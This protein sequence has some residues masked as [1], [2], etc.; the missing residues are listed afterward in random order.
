[1]RSELHVID[2]YYG[3]KLYSIYVELT[4]ICYEVYNEQYMILPDDCNAMNDYNKCDVLI[5]DI[6]VLVF[7][8]STGDL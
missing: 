1:M 6:W 3:Q 7:V 8:Y 4:V 2:S 5:C